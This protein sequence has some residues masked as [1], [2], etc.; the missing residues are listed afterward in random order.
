M[1]NPSTVWTQ[2]SLPNPAAGSI[3]FVTSDNATVVTD[4]L[5]F[6]YSGGLSSL[7]AGTFSGQAPYQLTVFGGLRVGYTDSRTD[8]ANPITINKCSGRV[9]ILAAGFSLVVNC[10]YCTLNSMVILSKHGVALTAT[11][12][13]SVTIG[14]GYFTINLEVAAAGN[15]DFDFF[16]INRYP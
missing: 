13:H 10:S 8:P 11:P 1:S 7:N 2:L 15:I 4:V 12:P 14:P 6:M 9:R 16:V 3:P 5:N